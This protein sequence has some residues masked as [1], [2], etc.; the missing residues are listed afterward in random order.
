MNQTHGLVSA[1]I[2]GARWGLPWLCILTI[3]GAAA[4]AMTSAFAPR[5]PAGDQPVSLALEQAPATGSTTSG[6]AL[7]ALIDPGVDPS[8]GTLAV[9]RTATPD[10]AGLSSR[11]AC[12]ASG[13]ML[14]VGLNTWI[15]DPS[16]PCH[17]D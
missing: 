15:H 3:S 6:G 14:Y 16:V 5:L 12:A 4:Y 8:A 11:E 1:L 2:R 17:D 9:A 10:A 13:P 7:M